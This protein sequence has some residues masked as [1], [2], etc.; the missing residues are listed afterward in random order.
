MESKYIRVV[1]RRLGDCRL[2]TE[3]RGDFMNIESQILSANHRLRPKGNYKKTSV[4]IHS[5]GNPKSTAENERKWLD[6]PSNNRD[7]SWHYVVGEN[8]V[9]QA[10]PDN[11]EAWHSGNRNGNKYSIGI[12]IIESGDRKKVLDNAARFVALKL[13]EYGLSL[14]V[15]KRHYDW[16]GKLCPRILLDSALIYDGMDWNY[17]LSLVRQYRMELEEV[18]KRYQTINELPDW[19]KP[20]I[21]KLVDTGKIADGNKLDMTMDMVRILVIMNR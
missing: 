19:A 10:I 11:E 14:D 16:S 3:L 17:F 6:N 7:A 8:V 4:T 1:F 12:E 20:T 5:T 13:K 21:Q 15:V 2:L 18:E 9:I